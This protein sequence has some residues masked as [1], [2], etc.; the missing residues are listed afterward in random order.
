MKKRDGKEEKEKYFS[1]CTMSIN[2]P[3]L[4]WQ[5]REGWN[6]LGGEKRE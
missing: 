5:E 2:N 4:K 3:P 6:V 1:T